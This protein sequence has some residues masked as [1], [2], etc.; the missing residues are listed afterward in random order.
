M[1]QDFFRRR[2]I[3]GIQVETA[4]GSGSSYVG[5]HGDTF[6]SQ[7]DLRKLNIDGP[8]QSDVYGPALTL[9]NT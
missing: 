5:H 4:L 9:N 6:K 2:N 7:N 3:D 8:S 1:Y